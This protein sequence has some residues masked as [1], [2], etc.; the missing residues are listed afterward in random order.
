MTLTL[1]NT[2]QIFLWENSIDWVSQT[3][4]WGTPALTA[5][6]TCTMVWEKKIR[7]GQKSTIKSLC[8]CRSSRGWWALFKISVSASSW[9]RWN[10]YWWHAWAASL[11]KFFDGFDGFG[12]GRGG[13]GLVL[14]L[15]GG[16]LLRRTKCF[17]LHGLEFSNL[18]DFENR[19]IPFSGSLLPTSCKFWVLDSRAGY[20]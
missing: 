16:L 3:A 12:V 9:G 6:L 1:N 8:T 17:S 11:D 4:G 19:R 13:F 14:S 20:R 2:V 5:G 10:S 7:D 15:A 18:W